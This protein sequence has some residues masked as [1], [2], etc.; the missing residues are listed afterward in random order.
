MPK[1]KPAPAKKGKKKP[2]PLR[3]TC[4]EGGGYKFVTATI[5]N[6]GVHLVYQIPESPIR[7]S[8]LIDDDYAKSYTED[9]VRQMVA[10]YLGITGGSEH[11]DVVYD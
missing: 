6:D 1:K 8:D 5:R 2:P 4:K 10:R 9:E 7:G 11:I 3:I